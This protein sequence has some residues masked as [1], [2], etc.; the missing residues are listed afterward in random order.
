MADIWEIVV[1]FGK[2]FMED[3]INAV[4]ALFTMIVMG[5]ASLF[6]RGA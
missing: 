3:P 5:I 6:N 4:L 2:M 1:E